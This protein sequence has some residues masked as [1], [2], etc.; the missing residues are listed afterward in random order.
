MD[1][2]N[3]KSYK[4]ELQSAKL[5]Q[6]SINKKN[7]QSATY[8]CVLLT[9]PLQRLKRSTLF[10]EVLSIKEF[11]KNLLLH[12]LPSDFNILCTH[13]MFSPQ[14]APRAWTGLPSV[15]EKV[16]I[17]ADKHQIARCKKFL[18]IFMRE[19]CR[20]VESYRYTRGNVALRR[21]RGKG[22]K[23]WKFSA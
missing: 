17:V 7:K 14:S 3:P 12:A 15:Y 8:T 23:S 19:G 13:P 20:M 16:Q 1:S 18:G 21:G 4:Q 6:S 2:E 9:L 5:S 22:N 10:V 11:P